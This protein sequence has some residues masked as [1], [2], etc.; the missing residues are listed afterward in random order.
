M[1]CANSQLTD[2]DADGRPV[3]DDLGQHT[4]TLSD[5]LTMELDGAAAAL[6]LKAEEIL[7]AALGRAIERTIGSLQIDVDVDADLSGH[8]ATMQSITLACAGPAVLSATEMLASVHHAISTPSLHHA[9]ADV[10]FAAEVPAPAGLGH[11]LEL[12]TRR[13]GGD[14]VLDWWFDMRSFEPYT[15]EEL[16]EQF[17]LALIELTSEASAPVA[18]STAELA[19]A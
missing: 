2:Y 4:A 9:L 1:M 11:S 10:L 18:V 5:V 19:L 14:L 12:H 6:G 15:V 7:V 3:L 8:G 16:A 13:V 17:P